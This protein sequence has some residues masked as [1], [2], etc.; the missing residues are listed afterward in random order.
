M[1]VRIIKSVSDLQG[2]CLHIRQH[3]HLTVVV[4]E[5][6]LKCQRWRKYAKTIMNSTS[7]EYTQLLYIVSYEEES[8]GNFNLCF[9]RELS[10]W[11][12]Q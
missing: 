1:Q 8:M 3:P 6:A 5:V 11:T 10:S 7:S 12:V 9:S 2:I 4:A